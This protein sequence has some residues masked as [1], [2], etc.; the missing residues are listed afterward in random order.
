MINIT[1]YVNSKKHST[2]SNSRNHL[3]IGKKNKRR[4][5]ISFGKQGTERVPKIHYILLA[6]GFSLSLYA[7]EFN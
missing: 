3:L 2:I 7:S 6:K 1:E 4:N 5:F